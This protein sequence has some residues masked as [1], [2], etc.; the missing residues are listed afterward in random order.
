[1]GFEA[2]LGNARIKQNL[3][4]ALQQGRTSHFY[5]ISGP[6]GSGKHTL[7][8]LLAAALLCKGHDRPCCSCTSCRKVLSG[9]HPDYSIVDDPEKKVYPINL[10]RQ[11]TADV[12]IRPNEGDKKIYVLPRGQDMDD[13]SQNA[14]LKVLEEPPS[15]GVFILLTTRPEKMLA[16]VR[17]R[18]TELSLRPVEEGTLLPWLESRFPKAEREELTA[19]VRRSGGYAGQAEA[20]LQGGMELTEQTQSF[21]QA[22]MRRDRYGL[23]TILVPM[24]KWQR[25]KVQD[26]LNQ[27]Q[28]LLA[29]ALVHRSGG[30][31]V[32]PMARQLSEARNARD[33]LLAV[34]QLKKASLYVSRNV[35]CGAVCGW[36]AQTLL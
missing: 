34:E 11:T 15:H 36:L 32:T 33:L 18:C 28:Q 14:L 17:S 24:E 3:R 13:P 26:T 7:A 20:L 35:S 12:Y 5:M 1:M 25:E 10:V 8:G 4:S 27:W 16:T 6:E 30:N 21:L 23:L 2:L 22:F 9:T 29:G 19:A 31:A